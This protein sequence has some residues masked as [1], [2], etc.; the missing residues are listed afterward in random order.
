MTIYDLIYVMD[1]MGYDIVVQNDA[2]IDN[3]DYHPF[4][5][6]VQDFHDSDLYL[7]IQDEEVTDLYTEHD[8]TMWIC[9]VD[10]EEGI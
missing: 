9:Y 2:M 1:N 7:R 5:G 3:D 8:G 6:D 10:E 4:R